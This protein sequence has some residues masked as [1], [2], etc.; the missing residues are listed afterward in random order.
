MPRPRFYFT[1]CRTGTGVTSTSRTASHCTCLSICHQLERAIL[2]TR[3]MLSLLGNMAVTLPSFIS[4]A[5]SRLPRRL[6][7]L[8][9]SDMMI[10]AGCCARKIE[11]ISIIF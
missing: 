2:R 11:T 7:L 9:V 5:A 3:T 6:Y 8:A 1:T 4:A 10:F